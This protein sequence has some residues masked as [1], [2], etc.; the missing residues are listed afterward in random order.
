MSTK[1]L[2]WGTNFCPEHT[3]FT[4]KK[5]RKCLRSRV[6]WITKSAKQKTNDVKLLPDKEAVDCHLRVLVWLGL[7]ESVK[8]KAR[9]KKDSRKTFT[10]LIAV[11]HCGEKESNFT[12]F[13]Q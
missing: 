10:N 1:A 4:N 3:I 2:L 13:P 12:Q 5:A 9:H 11:V 7:K 8:D 6:I